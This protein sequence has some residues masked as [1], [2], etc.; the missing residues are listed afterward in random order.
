[1][2]SH[3]RWVRGWKR[4]S[5]RR[6]RSKICHCC[7]L[8]PHSL[9]TCNSRRWPNERSR[10]RNRHFHRR[11]LHGPL[12]LISGCR[13]SAP[14]A[15]GSIEGSQLAAHR[16]AAELLE[17]VIALHSYL[18]TSASGQRE[19]TRNWLLKVTKR[20]HHALGGWQGRE[21]GR[22]RRRDEDRP[23][24]GTTGRGRR[25]RSGKL[26]WGDMET[27]SVKPCTTF[28]SS[29][30]SAPSSTRHIRALLTSRTMY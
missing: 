11:R 18:H 22:R 14:V 26:G 27:W 2:D 25:G 20:W 7:L 13:S 23:N 9:G 17:S 6:Q 15:K 10:C 3:W 28:F 24:R 1:M 4:I 5:G 29:S 16:L 21:R 12:T 30:N 8:V 19:W